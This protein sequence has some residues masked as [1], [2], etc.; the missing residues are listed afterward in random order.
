MKYRKYLITFV[1]MFVCIFIPTHI[2]ADDKNIKVEPQN[3]ES[4]GVKLQ[5][6]IYDYEQ[7]EAVTYIEDSW[8]P[9]SSEP[10]DRG[11]NAIANLF[12][13]LTKMTA[14]L[15]DTAIEELYGL[16]A[17]DRVADKVANVSNLLYDNLYQSLGILLFV[18]A[19][20]QIFFY[21]SFEKNSMK[22]GRTT[23]ALFAVIAVSM[24][25]FSNA[26][27]YLKTMNSLSNE[28][29][30]QVMRAGIPFSGEQVKKGEELKGSLAIMRNTYFDLVVYKSYLL[31]NYGTPDEKKIV[32]D[33]EK[34]DRITKLLEYKTNK[35]GYKE[36]E[37]IAKKEATEMDNVFMSA[38]TVSGKIGVAFFSLL[39]AI[40]LGIPFLVIAFLNIALQILL[41]AFAIVLGVSLLLSILPAF[42]QSGWK[43]FEKLIGIALMKAF[44]GLAIL[45]MF[46]IVEL[47]KSFFPPVSQGMYMLNIVATA[48]VLFVVYK[49]RD[50]I[51]EVATGGRVSLEGANP[52]SQLYNQGVKQ[53]ASKA[54]ELAKM[55]VGGAAGYTAG[56]VQERIS[57]RKGQNDSQN[58]PQ[59]AQNNKGVGVGGVQEQRANARKTGKLAQFRKKALNLPADLKD[60]AKTAKEAVKEDLPLNAKHAALKAKDN[61]VNMPER[62]KQAMKGDLQ[63]GEQE[64]QMSQQAREQK[65]AQKRENIERMEQSHAK[66]GGVQQQ[67]T[68]PKKE[69]RYQQQDRKPQ[70]K[71]PSEK[72][73]LKK[74]QPQH[75]QQQP[76]PRT[77]PKR[78]SYVRQQTTQQKPIETQ[79]QPRREPSKREPVK[80]DE[81][82]K[83]KR[84]RQ[85]PPM[86]NNNQKQEVNRK[87]VGQSNTEQQPIS[88]P[89]Q[90]PQGL[91]RTSDRN[92]G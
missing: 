61:I 20:L 47:M 84:Q 74:E 32:D 53:P 15:I 68:E 58:D 46:V 52:M 18:I 23:F 43:N 39:F 80:Q 38:S 63:Q 41:L 1:L 79:E 77:Q 85:E 19:V 17:I 45:F 54:T 69:T 9:F 33:N 3:V 82:V 10:L 12:F 5:S 42:S 25:W 81:I 86:K 83:E 57:N 29:Q 91:N 28:L 35:E 11:L 71:T 37:K 14:S 89:K 40:V 72:P 16:N 36:R 34:K 50:K 13:S 92:K 7:Y 4:G 64:R 49:Y 62:A 73:Q 24:I 87:V 51:I 60:K 48:V 76:Q 6:K 22:A 27:H 56:K 26:G 55:A 78:E 88:S 67:P 65:R 75:E 44:I 2:L 8:N 70:I 21:Y 90:K 30:G 59:I 66:S 31:M